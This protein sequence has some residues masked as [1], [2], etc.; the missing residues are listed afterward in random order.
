MPQD[1]WISTS[2]AAELS[3]YHISHIRLLIRQGQLVGQK[4]GRD[5]MVSR[6]SLQTYL[7][8]VKSQGQK[9]GRKTDK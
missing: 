6:E 8:Q 4:W 3:G 1:D 2:Q 7:L 5:W 9:R